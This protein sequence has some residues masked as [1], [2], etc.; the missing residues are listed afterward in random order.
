LREWPEKNEPLI[1]PKQFL[2]LGADVHHR[3]SRALCP[4]EFAITQNGA[5]TVI[6]FND[7]GSLILKNVDG[8]ISPIGRPRQVE[9]C[10]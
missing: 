3:T 8:V 7:G 6:S 1:L 4:D 5:D 9:A 2:G 10:L